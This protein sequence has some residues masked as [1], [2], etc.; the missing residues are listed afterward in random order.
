MVT[1]YSVFPEVPPF[2]SAVELA[3]LVQVTWTART[4][5]NSRQVYNHK[6]QHA[7]LTAGRWRWWFL[8]LSIA[9]D[10]ADPGWDHELVYSLEICW[11]YRFDCELESALSFGPQPLY[12]CLLYRLSNDSHNNT[13]L[14]KAFALSY[15]EPVWC[16]SY[17]FLVCSKYKA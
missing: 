16:Y 9:V 10:A 7:K 2:I 6:T 15:G 13:F 4:S 3:V 17:H 1:H 12:I 14:A 8:M 11:Q 5:L